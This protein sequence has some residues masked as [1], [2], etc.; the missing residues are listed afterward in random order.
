[1]LALG[2][3]EAARLDFELVGKWRQTCIRRD[4]ALPVPRK[5]KITK[6]LVDAT[7]PGAI[8]KR[9]WDIDLKGFVLGFSRMVESLTAS[10]IVSARASAG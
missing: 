6:R 2:S 9:V 7:H 5:A 8:E 1:L 10:N 3:N 4:M